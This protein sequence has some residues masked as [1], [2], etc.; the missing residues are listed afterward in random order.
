LYIN[1]RPAHLRR[2]SILHCQQSTSSLDFKYNNTD[3]R[4]CLEPS[5]SQSLRSPQTNISQCLPSSSFHLALAHHQTGH[6]LRY[7]STRRSMSIQQT[8]ISP[9][10]QSLNMEFGASPSL[11]L[12]MAL[13]KITNITGPSAV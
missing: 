7:P 3:P 6:C 1:C 12:N 13:P 5:S 4:Y 9:D 2:V 10:F 8:R 11:P